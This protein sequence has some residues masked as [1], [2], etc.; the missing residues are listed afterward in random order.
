MP[1]QKRDFGLPRLTVQSAARLLRVPVPVFKVWVFEQCAPSS[2]EW[3]RWNNETDT[4]NANKSRPLPEAVIRLW[5]MEH[6][7]GPGGGAVKRA[8]QAPTAPRKPRV[9][10][11]PTPPPNTSE[12]RAAKKRRRA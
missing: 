5:L 8:S 3:S 6:R 11:P 2:G 10:R 1:R 7:R 9:L 12:P 4:D